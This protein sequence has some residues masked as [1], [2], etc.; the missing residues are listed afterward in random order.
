MA[1]LVNTNN[2]NKKK[3]AFKS[4]MVSV[5]VN[6]IL[7][8]LQ[9][10]VGFF[11]HSSALIADGIHSFSDLLS[12]FVVLIAN[13][14]SHKDADEDHNYGHQRYETGASLFV[15][16]SLVAVGLSILYK[17]GNKIIFLDGGFQVQIGALWIAVF[18]L[19]SKEALFHYMINLA[20]KVRSQ[21]LI[22]NA[23][24]ARSDAISSLLVAFSIVGGLFGYKIFDLIGAI[25]VGLMIA[26]TGWSFSWNALH[27]L[28]D[29]SLSEEE[30]LRIKN[31]IISTDRVL[32]CGQLKTRKMGDMILVDAYVKIDGKISVEE[33]YDISLDVKY[34]IMKEVPEVLNV[35]IHIEPFSSTFKREPH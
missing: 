12:D 5:V 21:M 23:W 20:K 32:D 11:A 27:D 24:H 15:G 33:G 9:V 4:T 29:R 26:K 14:H 30:N 31:I 13:R 35:M 22:A 18:T 1:N 25:I 3:I 7:G 2:N 16:F 19:L 34:N 8:V 17:A 6:V 10:I 28:M